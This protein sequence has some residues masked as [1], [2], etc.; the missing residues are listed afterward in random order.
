MGQGEDP[1]VSNADILHA[2]N[3]FTDRFTSMEQQI[4]Q[5]SITIVNLSKTV[6]FVGEELKSLSTRV[7]TNDAKLL[8]IEQAVQIAQGKCDQA[9]IYTR[10][11][12]LRMNNL[13]ETDGENIRGKVLEILRI[14]TPDDADSIRF[15]VDTIHRIGRS[16]GESGRPRPVII[17]FSMRTYREKVERESGNL[18]GTTRYSRKGLFVWQKI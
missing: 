2:V 5:N 14:L 11:W 15:Y 7:K 12:N 17:Q 3:A 8:Q 6:D 10:R 18:R 4:A 16:G 1:N 13:K 9:E